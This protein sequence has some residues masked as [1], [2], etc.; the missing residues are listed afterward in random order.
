MAS[1]LP[2]D[3][4]LMK[5]RVRIFIDGVDGIIIRVLCAQ[6]CVL[7]D[8]ELDY[9]V[10]QNGCKERLIRKPYALTKQKI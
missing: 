2:S 9:L 5:G 1:P 7:K 8:Y 10:R 3:T 4:V 6:K